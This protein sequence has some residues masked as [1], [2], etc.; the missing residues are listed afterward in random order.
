MTE[1]MWGLGQLQTH[2]GPF[3]RQSP[4]PHLRA[5]ADLL[6]ECRERES[7]PLGNFLP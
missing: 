5:R 2:R 6:Q 3:H 7:A 1:V 4:P